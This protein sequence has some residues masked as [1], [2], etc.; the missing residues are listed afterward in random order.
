MASQAY[1]S[2]ALVIGLRYFAERQIDL[3][4]VEVGLGGRYDSANAITPLL[5]IITSISYD[6]MHILGDTLTQ[7][8]AEKAGI[9]KPG[10]PADHQ[11]PAARGPGRDRP[12]GRRRGYA[13]VGRRQQN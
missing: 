10:V 13:A 12:R 1:S 3:A 9:F 4:I 11:R 5:S 7:I 6:H 2:L 8:A